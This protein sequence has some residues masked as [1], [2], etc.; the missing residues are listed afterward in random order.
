MEKKHKVIKEMALVQKFF[1]R[2]CWDNAC[3]ECFF[4][5]LKSK[6]FHLYSFRTATLILSGIEAMHMMKKGKLH[7]RLKSA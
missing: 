4:S 3:I 7:Q 2:N 1:T 5:H 6:C